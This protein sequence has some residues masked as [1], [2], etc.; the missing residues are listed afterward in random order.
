M[1]KIIKVE[2]SE[3]IEQM[4]CDGYFEECWNSANKRV[5]INIKNN[6]KQIYMC[7]KCF[8]RLE[9]LDSNKL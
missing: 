9:K 7:D 4:I 2:E 6:T 3:E 5:T 8:E 1:K